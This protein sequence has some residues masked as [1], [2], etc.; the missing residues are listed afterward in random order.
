MAVCRFN[1]GTS[2]LYDIS[3]HLGLEPSP[4]CKVQLQLKELE[5][6]EKANYKASE[7]HKHLQKAARA[8]RKGYDDKNQEEEGIMYSSGVFDVPDLQ[9]G[10]SKRQKM[11]NTHYF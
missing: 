9:V 8:K 2:S 6:V 5:R 10:P 11:T 1:D 3:K 7:H 4:I